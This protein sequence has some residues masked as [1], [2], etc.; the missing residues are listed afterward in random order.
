MPRKNTNLW[1]ALRKEEEERPL[2]AD[3]FERYMRP[4]SKEDILTV[5][6]RM[7]KDFG[8]KGRFKV[9][10]PETIQEGTLMGTYSPG[11]NKIRIAKHQSGVES[12][13]TMAH[14]LAHAADIA[15]LGGIPAREHFT[16]FPMTEENPDLGLEQMVREQRLIEA[17]FPPD[18]QI[19][20]N[21][22]LLKKVVPLS[23]QPLA[24]PWKRNPW[25]E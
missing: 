22:P 20:N 21:M 7:G 18:P 10:F 6:K 4:E 2:G 8:L 11:E 23:S 19:V 14:E 25:R 1:Q 24:V 17:G 12:L 5:M 13:A 16:Y 15:E 3:I 9:S